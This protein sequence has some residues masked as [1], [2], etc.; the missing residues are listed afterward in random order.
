MVRLMTVVSVF[1]MALC[2]MGMPGAAEMVTTRWGGDAAAVYEEGF[3]HM[4]MKHQ[5][6]GV[7]LFNMDLVENDAPGAGF[8]EKGVSNDS[9]WGKNRA[10][11]I[12]NLDDPRAHGAW[13]VIYVSRQGKTP[14]RFTVN[15]RQGQFDN[16]D[17]R[18]SHENYR[19][20]R[21]PVDALK[22]GRNV[23]D[24]FCPEAAAEEEGWSIQIA[25]ADEFE[26]GGGDPAN[27]GKT[28]FKSA[29]GG[30][31][32]KES[33]F[34]P[35]GQTRAEYTIRISLDRFVKTGWLA[36]PVIDLWKGDSGELIVPLRTLKKTRIAIQSAVPAGS[37][38]E[39]YMRRG[40]APGPSS[41]AW[42]PY[43]L[44]GTG[45]SVNAE[46]AEADINRRYIQLRAVLKTDNPLESPVVR[47]MKVDAELLELVPLHKNLYILDCCNPPVQYSSIDWEWEKW[48]RPE[49]AELKARE[50]L[51]ELVDGSRTEFNAQ[52]RLLDH[53]TK[54]WR[55]G[56]PQPEYPGWDAKSILDRIDKNGGG[57]M[58]IQFNNALGGLCMAYGWQARLVN[59]IG[60]E[61][62]EVWND[63][64]AK[65]IFLDADYT[66][67]YNY[68]IT[69]GE[70]QSMLDLHRKFLDYYFPDRPIDWMTD[71]INWM[72]L[73]ENDP[74]PVKRGSLTNH[75]NVQLSGFINAAFMRVVPRNNWYEKPYPRPLNHGLTQWP[76]DGY[77]N[78]YDD[79]TPPK[80]QYSWF[81]DRPRD[82]WPDLNTVHIDATSSFGSDRLFLRFETYTPNFSHF[83]VNADDTGWKKVGTDRW[84]WFL[85]SGRN[86]LRVRAVSKAGVCGKPSEIVLNHADS[87]LGAFMD[88]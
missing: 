39:Y 70:P 42:E 19:W 12:F 10:R 80:R 76:W 50:N 62:I 5:G 22:K 20:T 1:C 25:R 63:E 41:D 82:L 6:G 48:D 27:V 16:W 44:I 87:Y 55:H 69:N 32:W 11:K 38:I 3:M 9:I 84:V 88:E 21:F 7:S 18:T 83:E 58:C 15:G 51:D 54:R 46:F 77:V 14:L 66:D 37:S 23:V 8:S 2:L 24:F 65:W 28:S 61:I 53:V 33:P 60:H 72:P 43:E 74:P 79:R 75:K 49:F 35:L 30:E 67:H 68:D 45:A 4:L 59:C 85:Q 34:G 81:T 52:V 29:D 64:F 31:S 71:T 73:R 26:A 17:P 57:G 47:S 36:S 40:T 56:S 78:W 13:L 86:T